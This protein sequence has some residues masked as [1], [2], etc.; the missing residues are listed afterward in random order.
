MVCAGVN[1]R[2]VMDD[3][4]DNET[5]EALLTKQKHGVA[6]LEFYRASTGARELYRFGG[7]EDL[8]SQLSAMEAFF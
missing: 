6:A 1:R 5:G 7:V 4:A 8:R 2:P 3:R